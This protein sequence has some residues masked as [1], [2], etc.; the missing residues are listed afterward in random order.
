MHRATSSRATATDRDA[1]SVRLDA[2]IRRVPLCIVWDKR[3]A[4]DLGT[5]VLYH[6]RH[7]DT[8]RITVGY[9]AYWTTERPFGDNELTRWVLPAV[10]I[11][12]VYSHLL[13]VLPGLQHLLYGPGDVE[14]VR[15]TY[16]IA[17]A[18]HLVPVDVTADDRRHR[19]VALELSETID[20]QGRIFVL[21]DTWS[22]QLGGP[23]AMTASRAGATKRCF[24]GDALRVLPEE[25]VRAF[26]LGSTDAPRRAKPAWRLGSNFA[27]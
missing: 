21:N 14:G 10:A 11:D 17:D 27:G 13:F 20:E 4:G 26:R 8:D 2:L 1:A 19:E 9:F 5:T 12:A 6:S 15:V 7:V 16:R 3:W 24:V 22:H 23:R 25:T 18:D